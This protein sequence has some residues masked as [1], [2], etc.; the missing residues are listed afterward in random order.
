MRITIRGYADGE[1]LFTEHT[2]ITDVD[3]KTATLEP[4]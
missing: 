2:E 3:Q 1:L 4:V